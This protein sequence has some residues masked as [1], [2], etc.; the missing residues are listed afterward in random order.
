MPKLTLE[1][2]RNSTKEMLTPLEVSGVLECAP[3]LINLQAHSD[4]E[5]GTHYLPFPVLIIGRKVKVPRRRF[6]EFIEGKE[7]TQ[8]CLQE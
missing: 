4:A 7:L 2:I 8:K 3:Y 6:L 1:E 5:K